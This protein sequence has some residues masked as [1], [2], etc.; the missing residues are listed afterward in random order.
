[1][2]DAVGYVEI[3]VAFPYIW[4]LFRIGLSDNFN[5]V[6]NMGLTGMII[7]KIKI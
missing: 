4:K 6:I 3:H 7:N 5:G 2:K 1:M